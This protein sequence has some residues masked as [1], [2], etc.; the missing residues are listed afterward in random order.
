MKTVFITG[1]ASGI[2]LLT[3]KLFSRKGYFVGLYDINSD[4][5]QKLLLS[6]DFPNACGSYCDVTKND[7]IK[8][9]LSHFSQHTQGKFGV[10]INNAGVLSSGL[11]E[12]L[13]SE[14]HQF[15]IDINIKG[16]TN[17][18]QFAHPYLKETPNSLMINLCSASSIHGIPYLA[19]YSATKHY[20]NGLSEAL[21]IEWE[22]DGIRVVS[23][24]PPVLNNKMG[25]CV[26]PN[27]TKK[28]AVTL[29]SE[30]VAKLILKAVNDTKSSYLLSSK[31]KVW[32]FINRFLSQNSR[33]GLVK[34]LSS[35]EK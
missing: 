23:I 4:E 3:A 35:F 28:M 10:L 30:D 20:V 14:Q 13:S 33:M 5:I 22:K 26:H 18:A 27:L 16:C 25:A 15:M 24:K 8:D 9:A 11:F 31:T 12:K 29:D 19:V 2:G 1:A 32:S 21:S 6:D 17:V 34:Y 7:S